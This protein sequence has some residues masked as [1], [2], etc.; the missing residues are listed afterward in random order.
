MA[1]AAQI[2]ARKK[3]SAIM[4]S[5]G[6]KKKAKTSST[7]RK[8]NPAAA[9]PAGTT[10]RQTL[11]RAPAAKRAPVARRSN[12]IEGRATMP[13]GYHVHIVDR[14]GEAGVKLATFVEKAPAVEYARGYAHK[15]NKQL[16]ILGKK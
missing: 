8:K 6:F 4:K 15:H 7:K 9:P 16:C 14:H 2:A 11:N 13:S 1:S 12:P 3:F 5:G 10:K